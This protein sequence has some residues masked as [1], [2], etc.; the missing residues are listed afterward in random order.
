MALQL[1]KELDSGISGDYWK[2][3]E[4]SLNGEE[5]VHFTLELYKDQAARDAGKK[6]LH[7]EMRS[8]SGEDNPCTIIAMNAVDVNPFKLLYDKLKLEAEFVGALDI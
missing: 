3:S 5:S 8:Y 6:P 7:G 4:L 2:V 1:A